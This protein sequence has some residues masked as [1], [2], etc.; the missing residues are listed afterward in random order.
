MLALQFTKHFH[1]M[2]HWMLKTAPRNIRARSPSSPEPKETE[3]QKSCAE[4]HRRDLD[5]TELSKLLIWDSSF[6][7]CLGCREGVVTTAL[8]PDRQAE[9]DK[10]HRTG[11]SGCLFP[12]QPLASQSPQMASRHIHTVK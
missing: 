11:A 1:S 7:S 8:A 3:A 4:G 10:H 5:E 6:H 12:S 2:P 9:A